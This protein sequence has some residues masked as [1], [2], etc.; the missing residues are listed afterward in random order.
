MLIER[1]FGRPGSPRDKKAGKLLNSM[2]RRV[3][4]NAFLFIGFSSPNPAARHLPNRSAVRP[5]LP[6]RRRRR[7]PPSSSTADS[8]IAAAT[9]EN[10]LSRV[11]ENEKVRPR[12]GSLTGAASKLCHHSG[13]KANNSEGGEGSSTRHFSHRV[14]HD[15]NC[16]HR[17]LPWSAPTTV[18]D[19]GAS[20]SVQLE[21]AVVDKTIEDMN[22]GSSIRK[23]G[24][25]VP[26]THG[27]LKPQHMASTTYGSGAWH[28]RGNTN[29]TV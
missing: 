9:V 8:T 5:T 27:P 1:R 26:T 16:R 3:C 21:K 20:R 14:N 7:P 2:S 10:V 11:N 4:T 24:D 18:A 15:E 6:H 22:A 29:K 28:L 19:M 12:A 23:H 13:S 25:K 17:R